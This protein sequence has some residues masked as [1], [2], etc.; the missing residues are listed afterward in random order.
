MDLTLDRTTPKLCHGESWTNTAGTRPWSEE[1]ELKNDAF[2][3]ERCCDRSR[4]VWS[5]ARDA[6][7]IRFLWRTASDCQQVCKTAG[8]ASVP[9]MHRSCTISTSAPWSL[10]HSIVLCISALSGD[11]YLGI[12]LAN[13]SISWYTVSEKHV[14][15]WCD[16]LFVFTRAAIRRGPVVSGR[17]IPPKG[18]VVSKQVRYERR[19]GYSADYIYVTAGYGNDSRFTD[20]VGSL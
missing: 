7:R 14:I 6:R 13:A 8:R 15:L 16:S 2:G 18:S 17:G 20:E 1:T 3:L 11:Y 19:G 5:G 10:K 9:A 12:L 4:E